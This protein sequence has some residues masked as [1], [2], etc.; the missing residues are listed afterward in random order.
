MEIKSL[1][2]EDEDVFAV[3]SENIYLFKR[4]RVSLSVNIETYT[5]DKKSK[6][7]I[8]SL[9]LIGETLMCHCSDNKIRLLSKQNLG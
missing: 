8:H 5:E 3:T 6:F 2:V 4:G 9:L 1:V 7:F